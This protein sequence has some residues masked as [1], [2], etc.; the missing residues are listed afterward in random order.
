MPDFTVFEGAEWARVPRAYLVPAR[1]GAVLDRLAAHGIQVRRLEAPQVVALERFR[2]DSTWT[3][4]RAFQGHNERTVRGAW[5]SATDTVPAGTAVVDLSQPLARL[6]VIL[7]D[8]RSDDGF[9]DW[10]LLD[11]ALAGAR[12]YPITRASS[13][14]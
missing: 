13:P 5:E 8:P 2:I 10:N 12:Y 7:L 14:L 6:A 3:S 1:L 11:D 4:P 9:L